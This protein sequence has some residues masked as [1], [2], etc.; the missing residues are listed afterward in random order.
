MSGIGLKT[1]HNCADARSREVSTCTRTHLR[2][3]VS[4]PAIA[5]AGV[6]VSC[7]FLNHATARTAPLRRP[8]AS[9]CGRLRRV[10]RGRRARPRW[11]VEFRALDYT[12]FDDAAWWVDREPAKPHFLKVSTSVRPVAAER[13]I[14]PRDAAGASR[15][16]VFTFH[17]ESQ[18][19]A[20]T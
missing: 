12:P 19:D 15:A 9:F 13:K 5:A 14:A 18:I 2:S 4:V 6:A 3:T 10:C 11:R 20:L 8:V 1:W 7:G 16:R 17:S